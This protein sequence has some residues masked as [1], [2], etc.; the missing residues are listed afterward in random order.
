M[1]VLEKILEFNKIEKDNIKIELMSDTAFAFFRGTSHLF[2]EHLSKM[3]HNIFNNRD[4]L[5]WIQGDS[6]IGNLGFSNKSSNSTKNIRFD[7]N[8]FDESF[9]ATPFLD[10]IRFC[11]SIGFFFDELNKRDDIE[12]VYK[13][14]EVMEQFLNN[15]FKYVTKNSYI[16]Y[17]FNESKFLKKIYQKVQKR[18]DVNYEKARINKFTKIVN[19]KR[20]FDYSNESII[21]LNKTI[22]EKLL[23]KLKNKY[24]IIDICKRVSAGVGSS[25]LNRFYMLVKEKNSEIL[26]E[27]KEQLLPSYLEHFS[28][29]KSLYK[30]DY[31]NY[32][33][34][35]IHITAKKEMMNDYD[36]H[37]SEINFEGKNYIIKSIFN[38][39]YSLDI[40]KFFDNSDNIEKFLNN[41]EDYITLC[42]ISLS[43]AHKKS[44]LNQKKFIKSMKNIS[45]KNKFEIE[46]MILKSYTT[47]ILM[48]EHFVRDLIRK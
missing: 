46:T 25:H 20:I 14:T 41:I 23:K 16:K 24:E 43:N 11:V 2:F 6:H 17:D 26:L 19:N 44:A 1:N 13:D 40:E 3:P 7:V 27:I 9:I 39:K 4:L 32:S 47:N 5:C 31:K 35:K 12:L 8:D 30:K 36:K 10:L 48:Y 42:A 18:V 28:K 15:Y 21:E 22:K 45:K 38:A 37:L 34:A 33:N 29:F